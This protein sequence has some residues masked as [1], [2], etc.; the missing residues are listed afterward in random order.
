[1]KSLGKGRGQT[2]LHGKLLHGVTPSLVLSEGAAFMFTH[3]I[4]DLH[5]EEVDIYS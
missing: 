3:E 1:M 4:A 5:V 2:A